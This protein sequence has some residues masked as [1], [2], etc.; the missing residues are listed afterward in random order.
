[1]KTLTIIVL[2]V[3]IKSCY[4]SQKFDISALVCAPGDAGIGIKFRGLPLVCL[5]SLG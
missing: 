2:R 5:A 3:S 4:K 1:M